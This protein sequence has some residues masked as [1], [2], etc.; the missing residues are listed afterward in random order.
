[1]KAISPDRIHVYVKKVF[2]DHLAPCD[3]PEAWLADLREM[4]LEKKSIHL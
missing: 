4:K 3:D 2:E 1:M